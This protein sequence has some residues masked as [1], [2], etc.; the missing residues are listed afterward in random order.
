[1]LEGVA[2]G[3]APVLVPQFTL[4]DGSVLMPLAFFRDAKIE[5]RGATTTVSY[6]QPEVDRM[7]KNVPASDDRLSDEVTY[8]F[9]PNRITRKDVFAARAP[10]DVGA[11]RMEFATFSTDASLSGH[12]AAFA[13]GAV[14]SFDVTGLNTCDVKALDHDH[15]YESD[16]GAMASL[17]RCTSGSFTLGAPLTISWS[18]SYR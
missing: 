8:T 15:D 13:G 10:L 17:V 5:T 2:D 6:R 16:T 14:T 1:M 12:R 4:K 3:T 9:E 18:I 7:G 11:I